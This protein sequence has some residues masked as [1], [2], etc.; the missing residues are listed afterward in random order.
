MPGCICATSLCL[1]IQEVPAGSVLSQ[2]YVALCTNHHG[3][4]QPTDAERSQ[5][6]GM[7]TQGKQREDGKVGK[8][9]PVA[10]LGWQQPVHPLVV[11]VPK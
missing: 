8:I 5:C 2:Q 6:S 3:S 4:A 7:W 11:T 9:M 1:H 10:R